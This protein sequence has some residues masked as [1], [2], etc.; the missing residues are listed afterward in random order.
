MEEPFTLGVAGLLLA[1]FLGVSG[2]LGDF[3]GVAAPF[4]AYCEPSGYSQR[5]ERSPSVKTFP[6]PRTTESG[7]F[8][9][10]PLTRVGRLPTVV[11]TTC[12]VKFERSS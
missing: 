1:D 6:W 9:F 5:N 8:T 11:R 3:L 12:K 2:V 10:F 4:L 7:L